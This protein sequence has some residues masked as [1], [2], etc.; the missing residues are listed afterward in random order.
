[1]VAAAGCWRIAAGWLI[2]AGLAAA[3]CCLLLPAVCWR[4]AGWL[5]AC[6]LGA[7][8]FVPG[9]S[10][11]F[12]GFLVPCQCKTGRTSFGTPKKVRS[13]L[14]QDFTQDFVVF[15]VPGQSKAG[16]TSC[17]DLLTQKMRPALREAGRT[18]GLS[19]AQKL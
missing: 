3:D 17:W 5:V 1:M 6:W 7:T 15:L 4:T 8:C 2:A 19:G 9:L 13:A 11:G 10:I 14:R 12:G 18:L 16:R